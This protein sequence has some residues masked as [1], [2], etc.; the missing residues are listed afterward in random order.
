MKKILALPSLAKHRSMCKVFVRKDLRA[1]F[2]QSTV[3]SDNEKFLR[4]QKLFVLF[5][6]FSKNLVAL[7]LPA[8]SI[9][10]PHVMIFSHE[11]RLLRKRSEEQVSLLKSERPHVGECL[12]VEKGQG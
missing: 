12:S 4:A 2:R 7:N 8:W 6:L 1:C 10:A 3:P 9:F 5:L 11:F